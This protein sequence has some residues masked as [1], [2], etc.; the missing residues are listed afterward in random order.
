MMR[1][2]CVCVCVWRPGASLHHQLA[3]EGDAGDV[4]EGREEEGAYRQPVGDLPSHREGAPDLPR[5]LPQPRQD[6]GGSPGSCSL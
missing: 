4:R 1:H 6:A 3:E 2:F 5:G